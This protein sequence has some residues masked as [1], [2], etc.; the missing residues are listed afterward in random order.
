M[1]ALFVSY[2]LV[3]YLLI[4]RAIFQ[5]VDVWLPLKFQRT[6]T[7]EVTFAAWIC[8]VS[9]IFGLLLIWALSEPHSGDSRTDYKLIFAGSYSEGAFESSQI[10]FWPSLWKVAVAQFEFLLI[11]IYCLSF[12]NCRGDIVRH[13]GEKIW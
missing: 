9:L 6:R 8:L 11:Y 1:V 2:F 13:I 12:S 5:L 10:Q 3:A 4:P 7:E